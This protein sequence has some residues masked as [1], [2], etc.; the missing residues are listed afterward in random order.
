MEKFLSLRDN[1]YLMFFVSSII[2]VVCFLP[3]R[4]IVDREGMMF[5]FL[6]DD[7][8][9]GK[10]IVLFDL[11]DD[12][13]IP[14]DADVVILKGEPNS[15]NPKD[16]AK[17]LKGKWV[18][19]LEFDPSLDFARKVVLL[20]GDNKFFRVHTVKQEEIK[21]LQLDEE[22]L[23]HRYKRA[24]IERSVEVLWIRNIESKDILV[25]RLTKYFEGKITSFPAP[26]ARA[27]KFPRWTL[28]IPPLFLLASLNPLLI[29]VAI[30]SIFSKEWFVSLLFSISTL[31]AYIIPKEKWL[32]LFSFLLLS[33]SLSL[34]LSD[35]YHINQ[36][37]DFRGVKLS[38]VLLPGFI[39]LKGLWENRKNWK[40]FLPVLLLFVPVGFYY[41]VRSGNSGWILNLE[42]KFRDWLEAVFIVRPRFKEIICYPFFWL[43]GFKEYD[44]LRESFGSI[45]LVSLFNTFCHIKTPVVVSLYRSALGIVIGYAV[46]LV[47]KRILKRFLTSK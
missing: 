9:D 38:L 28:L 37:M 32:K 17:D 5:S 15:W 16:L 12:E 2:L 40:K 4:I 36:I 33:V 44:F 39:L 34:S 3:A 47:L 46:Y 23:F 18:G 26:P 24:V 21:K 30:V 42:R 31:G 43:E 1:L 19:I 35:V 11:A 14:H 13:S 7:M 6:F 20:K 25:E 22:S 8:I 27:P 45:A 29:L 10:K 41:V